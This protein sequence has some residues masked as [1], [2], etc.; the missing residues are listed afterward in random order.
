MI[1]AV[2]LAVSVCT[3]DTPVQTAEALLWKADAEIA[4]R[5]RTFA[6]AD[7][8]AAVNTLGPTPLSVRDKTCDSVHYTLVR[9]VAT[10]HTLSVAVVIQVMAPDD[11]TRYIRQM[12]KWL[13]GSLSWVTARDIDDKYRDLKRSEWTYITA[14]ESVAQPEKIRAHT[15]NGPGCQ[16]KDVDAEVLEQVQPTDP[17]DDRYPLTK[18]VLRPSVLV[19]IAADGSVLSAA[20]SRSG[21]HK[22]LDQLALTEAYT[23]TYLP[24]VKNCLRVPGTVIF[25]ATFDPYE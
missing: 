21:L 13:F 18:Y 15:P 6:K 20:V 10:L 22:Y 1:T 25:T 23:S 5:N 11:A 14:I 19:N 9:Y 16:S 17:Y 24:A 4:Q 8:D 12:Q 3:A 2:L 7:Y